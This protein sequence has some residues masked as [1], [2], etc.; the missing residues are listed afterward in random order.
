MDNISKLLQEARPLY[1]RRR[2]IRRLICY[3]FTAIAAVAVL[4]PAFIQAQNEHNAV[5][6]L[7]AELYSADTSP[8][9]YYIDEFDA[10]GII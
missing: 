6:T 8:T 1:L 2:R 5:G 7:Y 4:M 9:E 3:N 10:I